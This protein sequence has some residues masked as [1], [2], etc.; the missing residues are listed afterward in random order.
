[1]KRLDPIEEVYNLYS[2][3]ETFLHIVEIADDALDLRL[4]LG[5]RPADPYLEL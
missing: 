1:M 5:D 4:D 2:D 3:K